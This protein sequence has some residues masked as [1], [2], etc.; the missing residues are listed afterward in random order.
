MST[1]TLVSTTLAGVFAS[2][3][4]NGIT[5]PL[6][7]L[8]VRQQLAVKPPGHPAARFAIPQFTQVMYQGF[9]PF[10]VGNALKTVLRFNVFNYTTQLLEDQNSNGRPSAPTV[11]VAGMFTGLAETLFVVPFESVKTTMI[12]A[13]SVGKGI[14]TG[15][16]PPLGAK[17]TQ[18]VLGQDAPPNA[19]V[20]HV[21]KIPK[22]RN[23]NHDEFVAGEIAHKKEA[24]RPPAGAS[25]GAGSSQ[26]RVRPPPSA[27]S[28]ASRGPGGLELIEGPQSTIRTVYTMYQARGLRAFVQGF[29]PT[30]IRQVTNSM[31]RFTAW[32][33]WT[34]VVSVDGEDRMSIFQLLAG[35]A[36]V[37]GIEAVF[38]QPIDVIKTRMQAA[39]G[40]KLYGNSL[41][42]AYRVFVEE[43]YK[44]LW[45]GLGLRWVRKWV[46]GGLV[47]FVYETSFNQL[48]K[49]MRQHPFK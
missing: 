36:V 24:T 29:N 35:S 19:H 4:E 33:S 9:T 32:N 49:S 17:G 38:T 31:L 40:I 13:S 7:Y 18:L 15:A 23:L 6:E 8:K 46:S 3:V 44:Q 41:V 30:V 47:W 48:D 26:R 45:A 28:S 22:A 39:N 34:Q 43:G 12:E 2:V 42:C 1:Q 27:P 21:P 20:P 5:F 25:V 11:V 37:S 14:A 10:V 16:L